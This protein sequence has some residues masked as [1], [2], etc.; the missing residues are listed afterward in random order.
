MI[1]FAVLPLV[2]VLAISWT[3]VLDSWIW[4]LVVLAFLLVDPDMLYFPLCIVILICCTMILLAPHLLVGE[5][6]FIYQKKKF[7]SALIASLGTN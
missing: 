1:A 5:A 4:D 3:P 6:C 7:I 2:V